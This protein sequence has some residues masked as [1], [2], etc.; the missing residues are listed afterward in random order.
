MNKISKIT[1]GLILTLGFLAAQAQV[2]V[3]EETK[4]QLPIKELF[5][6]MKNND[7]SLVRQAFVVGGR[8]ETVAKNKEGVVSVKST[9][10]TQFFATIASSPSGSLD[11]RLMGMDIKIDGDMATAWTPYEF[12]YNGQFSHRG[13]NA[14]QLVK[15]NDHWKIWSIIDTRRK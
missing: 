2:E 13:V 10:L 11:E 7:S 5:L 15:I 8:L 3:S 14:F 9:P 1:A 12:F 6:G 4:A